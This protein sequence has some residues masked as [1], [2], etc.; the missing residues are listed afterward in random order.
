M[1]LSNLLDNNLLNNFCQFLGNSRVPIELC[2][3][4]YIIGIL[5]FGTGITLGE[6]QFVDTDQTVV[7]EMKTACSKYKKNPLSI[8]PETPKTLY[9][10][11]LGT[12]AEDIRNWKSTS[13]KNAQVNLS[14]ISNCQIL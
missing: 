10:E 11:Y 3:L 1:I 5:Q 12:S 6:V 7:D 8:M 9:L 14:W 13:P 2:A 4:A